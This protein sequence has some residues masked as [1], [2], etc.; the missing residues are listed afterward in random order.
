MQNNDK[1]K[2]ITNIL[3]KTVGLDLE[4]VKF[5]NIEKYT[6][7]SEY[8]FYLI[9]LIGITK[10]GKEKEIFIKSIKQGK[11]KESLF[12]IC[13]L[14]YEKYYEEKSKKLKKI[15]IIETNENLKN[16]S[17]V[18]VKLFEDNLNF[19]RANIEIY[20]IEM[21]KFLKNIKERIENIEI[22]PKDIIIIGVETG[23]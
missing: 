10:K 14:A 3:N 7:I 16:I 5:K 20:F 9:N 1:Q 19:E 17:K 22:S 15:S 23:A 18:S 6:G 12:C 11:I 8:D 4:Q 21:S 13:D 2:R